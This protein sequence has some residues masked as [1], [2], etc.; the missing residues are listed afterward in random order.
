MDSTLYKN[1][2]ENNEWLDKSGSQIS[3]PKALIVGASADWGHFFNKS[4]G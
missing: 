3:E 1:D 4:V 2:K